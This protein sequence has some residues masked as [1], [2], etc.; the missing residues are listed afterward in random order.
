MSELIN[1]LKINNQRI[2]DTGHNQGLADVIEKQEEFLN[3]EPKTYYDA[4]WDYYQDTT[5]YLYAFSF[6]WNDDIYLPKK[7]IQLVGSNCCSGMFYYSKITDTKVKITFMVAGNGLSSAIGFMN[8]ATAMKTIREI[9]FNSSTTFNNTSFQNCSKL[10]TMNVSGTI[11][12]NGLNLQWSPLLNKASIKSI[13]NALSTTTEGLTV[14][15]SQTAVD[16]AFETVEGA[17]DG[18]TSAEWITLAGD[19]NTEG[20]RPNWTI[21]LV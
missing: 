6:L 5:Q 10:E 7:D 4:F 13:I 16:N 20:I 8:N 14:T 2:F 11:G 9:V 1:E 12:Q 18:S 19:E 21:S 17:A 15:L 3:G